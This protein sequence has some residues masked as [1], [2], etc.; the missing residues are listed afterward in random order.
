MTDSVLLLWVLLLSQTSLGILPTSTLSP[1]QLQNAVLAWLE[2][3]NV[4][5]RRTFPTKTWTRMFNPLLVVLN[6]VIML[7][8]KQKYILKCDSSSAVESRRQRNP[9][10]Q[11]RSMPN[12]PHSTAPDRHKAHTS[13][14]LEII[15]MY[16]NMDL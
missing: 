11:T 8:H 16:I 2:L 10:N 13:C 4:P 1:V 14:R 9:L 15:A 12:N 7:M 6:D 3:K 5:I